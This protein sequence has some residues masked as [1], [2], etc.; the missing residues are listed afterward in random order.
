MRFA[1][2]QTGSHHIGLG[3]GQNT[4][5]VY[6]VQLLDGLGQLFVPPRLGAPFVA[7]MLFVAIIFW[8]VRSTASSGLRF[9]AT[10]ALYSTAIVFVL[11]NVTWVAAPLTGTRQTI[12]VV[13][14]LAP[15][16]YLTGSASKPRMATA[17]LAM[18]VAG[19]LY[20]TTLHALGRAQIPTVYWASLDEALRQNGSSREF[21]PADFPNDSVVPAD[22]YISPAYPVG[23]PLAT[24]KGLLIAPMSYEEPVDRRR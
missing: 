11:F 24:S 4:A 20:W 14:I 21:G 19:Q 8:L 16:G 13:L 15:L 2:G 3:A 9:G 18:A 7:I 10:F 5:L 23:P 12:F 6:A 1:L 17:V 22:A